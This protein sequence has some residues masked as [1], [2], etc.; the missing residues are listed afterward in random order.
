MNT[1]AQNIKQQFK[2]NII[3]FVE[4]YRQENNLHTCWREPLMGFANATGAYMMSL[5]K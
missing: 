1:P 3:W 2:D 4:R 5:K